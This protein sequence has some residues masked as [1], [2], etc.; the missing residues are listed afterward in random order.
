MKKERWLIIGFI[1]TLA[2]FGLAVLYVTYPFYSEFVDK[3]LGRVSYNTNPVAVTEQVIEEST[4][5]DASTG[6]VRTEQPALVSAEEAKNWLSVPTIGIDQVP[7]IYPNLNDYETIES[8][9]E[10]G[11]V[12]LAETALPDAETGVSYVIG[13]SSNFSWAAGAYNYVFQYLQKMEPGNTIVLRYRRSE[14]LYT[15]VDVK[16]GISYDEA[17][18]LSFDKNR[19][20]LV[21]MTCWPPNSSF[22]RIAVIAEAGLR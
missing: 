10:E 5:V 18:A 17:R 19:K 2:V 16:K 20:Y 21:L 15:V 3:L 8:S 9:L 22:S 6:R 11:V 13:H 7:V 12:H 4:L 1:L 14:Y